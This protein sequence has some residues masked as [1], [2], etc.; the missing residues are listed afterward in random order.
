MESGVEFRPT[1]VLWLRLQKGCGRHRLCIFECLSLSTWAGGRI[2]SIQNPHSGLQSSYT[3]ENP[4]WV[5]SF[6]ERMAHPILAKGVQTVGFLGTCSHVLSNQVIFS[7][8]WKSPG[9]LI[10]KFQFLSNVEKLKKGK[11]VFS[12]VTNPHLQEDLLLMLIHTLRLFS[13]LRVSLEVSF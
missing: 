5:D 12:V 7:L 2:A 9:L 4:T 10:F 6:L 11:K 8:F 1:D 13:C 3:L